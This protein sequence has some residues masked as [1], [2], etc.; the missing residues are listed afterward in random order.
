MLPCRP[1]ENL[2]SDTVSP[3][4]PLNVHA[5]LQCFSHRYHWKCTAAS[6]PG[7]PCFTTPS[8]HSLGTGAPT[9]SFA[10]DT[11]SHSY[12]QF[13]VTL[14]VSSSGRNSSEAQVVLSTHLDTLRYHHSASL[15]KQA[16][17]GG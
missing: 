1:P 14:T 7:S 2:D 9:L 16:G 17:D 5:A 8:P 10:A 12:D 13:L 4:Q 3:D 6:S 15:T 11:L